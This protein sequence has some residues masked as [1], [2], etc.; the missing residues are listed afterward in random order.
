MKVDKERDAMMGESLEAGLVMD[1]IYRPAV[2]QC[3]CRRR[4]DGTG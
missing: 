4:W 1:F 3:R 2:W